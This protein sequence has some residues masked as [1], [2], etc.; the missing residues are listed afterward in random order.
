MHAFFQMV[1]ILPG[2][3]VG[4]DYVVAALDELFPAGV[5]VTGPDR[6]P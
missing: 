5:T 3:A 4:M 6:R 1:N 2:S